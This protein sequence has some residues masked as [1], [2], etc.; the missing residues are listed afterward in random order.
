MARAV[1]AG[2]IDRF[3]ISNASLADVKAVVK[4]AGAFLGSR[5]EYVQNEYNLLAAEVMPRR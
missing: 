1:E 2:K 5:F 4:L 3:G